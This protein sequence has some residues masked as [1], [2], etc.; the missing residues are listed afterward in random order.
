[1]RREPREIA[2]G[3]AVIG[4]EEIAAVVKVLRQGIQPGENVTAFE[5]RVAALLG[6][7]HGV[8]VNSGS[9]ALLV[10]MRLIDAPAG[11]EVLTSVLTFST[12]VA[13][14]VHA[15]FVPAFVDCELDTYQIDVDAIS[16]M[17]TPRTR[18]LLVPNL[19][20]GMPDWDRLEEIARRHDLLLIEDSCDTLGGTFRGRPAG[21]RARISLTSF[22]PHHI[23]TAMGTGGL[24]AI[25]S[26]EL[27]DKAVTLRGWGRSSEPF[28]Y[29]TRQSQTDGRFLEALDGMDYDAMFIFRELGYGFIPS[30]AGAAF[31]QAQLDKLGDFAKIRSRLFDSHLEFVRKH[32]DVFVAPRVLDGVVT[33]WLCF[34]VQLRPELGWSRKALQMHLLDAGIQNRLI[35]SG[36]MTRQPMLQG[37]T[38]RAD[39][40]GY[41]NA[42]Q[43]MRYGT[44][45]PCH[46]TMTDEDCEYLY[47]TLEGFVAKMR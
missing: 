22:S 11:S 15:G 41:P 1:M 33:T 46:P 5:R 21:E 4:E 40:A 19:V 35:F 32:E 36:N 25:D 44:M 3:G 27:W 9:S 42:D 18:A 10:A 2:Y 16:R 17:V 24:V 47:E 45:L 8:M 34:P 14:I 26:D 20:G 38:H 6:K 28:L 30:E 13:S 7:R 39:P 31:G 37:V 12:D 29:G 43:I 23:I